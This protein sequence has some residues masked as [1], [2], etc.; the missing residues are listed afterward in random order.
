MLD[1]NHAMNSYL[2]YGSGMSDS[3]KS[4]Y[5][6]GYLTIFNRVGTP[7]HSQDHDAAAK[8]M[9]SYDNTTAATALGVF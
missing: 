7:K 9:A 2:A 4:L 1:A 5:D 8:Q 3:F 6:A